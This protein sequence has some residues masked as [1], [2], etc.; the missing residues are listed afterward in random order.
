MNSRHQVISK[1]L[2]NRLNV[3]NVV[4]GTSAAGSTS[5]MLNSPRGIAV[6]TNLNLYVADCSNHRIQKY[7]YRQLN[8]TTVV[9]ATVAG[10]ISLNCPSEIIL[11]ADGYLF[12]TDTHN[13]RIIGSGPNGFRCIAAC[14]GVGS[15]STALYFPAKFSFDSYG[16]L[17]IAD[18]GNSRIQKFLLL[19]N[20]CGK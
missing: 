5:V 14:S 9:G 7:S 11:D 2:D 1:A 10:T 15:T 12:I 19:S 4:A 8:G 3:W 13:H 6:D 18:W 17:F 16:N 20:S